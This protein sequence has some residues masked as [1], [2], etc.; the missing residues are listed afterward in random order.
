VL[1]VLCC[2]HLVNNASVI[3]K[4]ILLVVVELWVFQ[5]QMTNGVQSSVAA[6]RGT[7]VIAFHKTQLAR[8]MNVKNIRGAL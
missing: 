6:L 4:L 3:S 2:G 7:V 5:L 8:M 1:G